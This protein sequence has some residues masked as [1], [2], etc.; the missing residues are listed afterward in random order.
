M[1]EIVQRAQP[2]DGL[3][4]A[5]DI[6]IVFVAFASLVP[7]MFKEQDTLL[8]MLDV[9]TVYILFFDYIMRWITHD[10]KTGKKGW[11]TFAKYPFTPL[12]I[13][14]LLAILPSLGIL[15]Q[16]FRFLRVLRVAKI[17]R[18]SKNL[19]I[20]TNVLKSERR[21][22]LAVLVVAIAYIFVSGL[23]MF[24]NE[25]DTFNTFFVALYWA[26]TALT[27]VGYGDIAPHTDLGM[28][29]S[30]ISSLFGIAVIA[31][32]AG[33]ITGGFLEEVRKSQEDRVAYFHSATPGMYKGRSLGSYASVGAYAK[34]HPKVVF[35]LKFMVLGIVLD[36]VLYNLAAWSG[37][38]LWLDTAG[39]ALVAIMLEPAAALIVGFVNNMYL[40][41]V[42]QNAG[43]L[44]YFALSAIVAL[45]Y[46][47]LFARGR[48]ITMRSIGIALVFL[49]GVS[50][51]I[52]L[53]LCY[54]F[55]G[56]VP[57][58]AGTVDYFGL[59]AGWGVPAPIA[60]F[61]A[62]AFDKLV[63][64]VG[65]F[66]LVMGARRLFKPRSFDSG[67]AADAPCPECE[68][69]PDVLRKTADESLEEGADAVLGIDVGGTSTKIGVFTEDGKLVARSTFATA[70]VRADGSSAKLAEAYQ[71]MLA[72]NGVAA[73]RICA[74]GLAV[75]GMV[76]A[77]ESLKLCPNVDLD[78]RA[79]KAFLRAEFPRAT[80]HV[81]NDADAAVLGDQWAGS[82][83]E[84][85]ASTFALLTLGTGVGAGVV[86]N[87][88]LV[89]GSNG[90][91][92]EI[93]HLC[94]EPGSDIVCGCGRT[95]CLE[96]FASSRALVRMAG[97]FA[98]D[99]CGGYESAKDVFDAAAAGD[100]A[101]KAA[102]ERFAD[103]L[104]FGLSQVACLV[105]PDLFVL[106]GGM[107]ASADVYLETIRE[108]YK[109]YALEVCRKTP[110]V[111]STLGNDCGMYGAAY[112]AIRESRVSH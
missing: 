106:G 59:L 53:G 33:I 110:I 78:L 10:F 67:E 17:F 109:R 3:S 98:S 55:D 94:V 29:I 52:S 104:A 20:V 79:Y 77:E 60:C 42:F 36:I 105:D 70:P 108:C 74:I 2:G 39:T 90:A 80:I 112:R 35:Y 71:M 16:T 50:A 103:R 44:L 56:G 68:D 7:L 27:T 18:Y 111:A 45:V 47:I 95:G 26:T 85:G 38:P 13:I 43:N 57:T 76:A 101:A 58:T 37:L 69:G 25:P 97:E 88:K 1:F 49:V 84:F 5:Y 11:K 82:A 92:G 89:T 41:V 93:G 22:L 23:I 34:A 15:P 14:D 40:A 91:V 64:A 81:I 19:M 86:V 75:P 8:T 96:Q 63:D 107:A 87:G 31:L 28:G 73:E 21:T 48:K 54:A 24:V 61:C 46:G 65:V 99:G 6:F 51:V 66:V 30:M 4:R 100:K 12:A 72:R 83:R 102:V 62:L 32:P 9:V